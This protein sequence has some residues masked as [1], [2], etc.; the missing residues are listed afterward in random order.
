LEKKKPHN[1]TIMG[2]FTLLKC[3]SEGL[4]LELKGLYAL[5]TL[6][7]ASFEE[8]RYELRNFSCL[9]FGGELGIRTLGN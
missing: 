5:L 9:P 4:A 6:F 1:F 7:F 3:F 2:L 8:V